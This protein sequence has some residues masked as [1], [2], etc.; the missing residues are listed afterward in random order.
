MIRPALLAILLIITP[1]LALAHSKAER[2]TPK[3]GATVVEV[4]ELLMQFDDP[5][6]IISV[7]LTSP[8]GEVEVERQTG[9]EPVLEFRASPAQVLTRGNY[10]FDWRGMAADGHPMQGRFSF[11]VS[12]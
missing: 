5:M 8:T 11:T 1:T 9:V 12:E 10:R 4:P 2:T 6:R 7:T 3:D